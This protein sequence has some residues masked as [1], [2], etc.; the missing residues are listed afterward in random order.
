MLSVDIAANRVG[1]VDRK[2]TPF[3]EK[4]R[5]LSNAVR[6]EELDFTPVAARARNSMGPTDHTRRV[7]PWTVDS[8]CVQFAIHQH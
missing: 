1:M 2:K 3:L 7:F 4:T 8:R 6:E 5:T